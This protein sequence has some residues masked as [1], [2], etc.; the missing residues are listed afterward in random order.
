MLVPHIPFK[1]TGSSTAGLRSLCFEVP[2]RQEYCFRPNEGL[3]S[4]A[5]GARA[6]LGINSSSSGSNCWGAPSRGMPSCAFLAFQ[7]I[8]RVLRQHTFFSSST[9]FFQMLQ[10]ATNRPRCCTTFV[11]GDYNEH[12]FDP[13]GYDKDSFDKYGECPASDTS[14]YRFPACAAADT[15]LPPAPA[16]LLCPGYHRDGH[17]RDGYKDGRDV[18][19]YD[20]QVSC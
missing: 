17:H 9:F 14:R 19:G 18:Y 7:T 1:P 2:G 4:C 15:P 11:Q 12:G 8:H 3:A 16:C 13:Q 6:C 10:P 20:E 5:Y